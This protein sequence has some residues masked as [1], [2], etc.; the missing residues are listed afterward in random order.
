MAGLQVSPLQYQVTSDEDLEAKLCSKGLKVVELHS[1]WCGTCKSVIPTF[2]RIRLD[3]DDESALLFVT[4]CSEIC[5][6]LEAAKDHRGKSEPLFLLYR[7][8]QL[9]AKIEGA[10]TPLL[11]SQILA[12]TPANADMDDLEENPLYLAKQER[13]RAARGEVVK[14]AKKTKKK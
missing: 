13:E 4:V 9:K 1:E 14:D 5:N 11:S 7:N 12:L 2:K 8:G 10:N 3:K 6:F